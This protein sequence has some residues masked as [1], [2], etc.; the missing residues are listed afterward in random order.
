MLAQHSTA[1][2]FPHVQ[3][4]VLIIR[5]SEAA[6]AILFGTLRQVCP[7]FASAGT[8]TTIPELRSERHQVDYAPPTRKYET[9]R[10]SHAVR[11]EQSLFHFQVS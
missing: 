11:H 8:S 3:L 1:H 2:Q 6:S 10:M 5:L 9:S 4:M 7:S